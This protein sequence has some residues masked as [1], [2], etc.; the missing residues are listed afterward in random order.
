[1][2]LLGA[3]RVILCVC[4]CVCARRCATPKGCARLSGRERERYR[5]LKQAITL[6]HG[7]LFP[8]DFQ[9][10]CRRCALSTRFYICDENEISIP[11]WLFFFCSL[12][13]YRFLFFFF[14]IVFVYGSIICANRYY[15]LLLSV[16]NYDDDDDDDH[17]LF[18]SFYGLQEF[19]RRNAELY[20]IANHFK[21]DV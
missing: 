19:L 7:V 3:Q 6:C 1:M 12:V 5:A 10:R 18:S 13:F 14:F 8:N 4:V 21:S 17:N 16:N 20:Y 9:M 2:K 15:I 11:V